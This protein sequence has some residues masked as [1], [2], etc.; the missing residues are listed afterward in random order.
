MTP[1]PDAASLLR[2][3]GLL[4]DGPTVWGRPV[5]AQGPGVFVIELP[6]PK[7]TAPI[8]LTKVG[9]WIERVDSLRMDGERPSSRALAGRL[10]SFWLP[11]HRS[12]RRLATATASTNSPSPVC[13]AR[14]AG[15]R[16][17]F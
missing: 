8:E 2:S 12:S 11:S 14:L 15:G 10:A 16:L 13:G 1:H 7:A 4:A 9:K 17:P 6:E 5:P 3:V